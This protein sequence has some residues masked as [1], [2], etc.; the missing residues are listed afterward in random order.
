MRW[1][2]ILAVLACPSVLTSAGIFPP[3]SETSVP[4]PELVSKSSFVCKGEVTWS[5]EVRSIAGPLPR[6]TGVTE[7]RIDRCFKGKVETPIRVASDEYRPSGGWA[8]AAHIFTPEKGE[9]LL[10]FLRKKD[11]QLYE[12][13]DSDRGA[14]P[15][16][17]QTNTTAESG[18]TLSDLENDLKAGLNDSDAEMVLKSICWLGHLRHLQSTKDLRSLLHD[19]DPIERT[20]LWEALLRVGD[21]SVIRDVA[22]YLEQHPPVRRPLFLPRDRLLHMNGRVFTAFCDLRDAAVIP[23][24]E[25]FTNSPD[26]HVRARALESLRAIGSLASAPTFLRALDDHHE[27]IDFIA[28]Q[29]LIALAGGGAIEWVPRFEDFSAAPDFYAAEC[30]EWWRTEGEAKARARAAARTN[31]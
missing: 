23:Y 9:Y 22:D 17:K 30:L 1:Q 20:Y 11:P 24:L 6:K 27:D 4:I 29:S 13:V 19:A 14:L 10:L 3:V 21:L 7:V 16:S 31:R 12:L 28:M 25:G 8:G 5:P 18:D 2:V 15:V 26:A